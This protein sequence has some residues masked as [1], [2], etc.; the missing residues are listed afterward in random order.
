MSGSTTQDPLSIAYYC[1]GHGLGH[2]TRSIE[3]CKHLVQRGHSVTVITA[4]PASFFLREI[5]SARL[6]LR[7]AVL[8]AGAKQLDPF[9]VDVKG[10][11]E[12][13]YN[14]VVVR[15]DE[16]LAGEVQWL[17]SN[18]I[19][20]VVSDVVPLVCAAA[21]AAGVPAVCVSNFSWGEL[22][23]EIKQLNLQFMSRQ[24]CPACIWHTGAMSASKLKSSNTASTAAA[25]V[26]RKHCPLAAVSH[27]L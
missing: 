5:P 25:A 20:L 19:D 3:V 9:T 10:S 11:L 7:K 1:T 12:D 15:R 16:M 23:C 26:S 21:A 18:H 27:L 8:D 6:V 14:T 13:Y 22:T 4:A 17:Q 24:P 2:A